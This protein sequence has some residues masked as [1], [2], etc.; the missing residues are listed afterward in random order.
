MEANSFAT[1]VTVSSAGMVATHLPLIL[2]RSRGPSGTLEGHIAR[3]NPQAA[4]TLADQDAL[5]IF[6]GPHAYISPSWYATTAE[7]GK[8][9]PTWNYVA[10][11]AYGLVRFQEGHEFLSRH[12][13]ALVTRHEAGR[14]N[15]W[16]ISDAPPQYIAQLARAI[17]GFEIPITRIEGKWKMSQN[18]PEADID[19]VIAGLGASASLHDREVAEIVASVRPRPA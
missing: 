5:V 11:H 7:H 10:V 3:A 8:V 2:D 17:V 12:L 16:S 15:P 18:R 13:E 6:T 4:E 14:E 9:V 1:V 19:G